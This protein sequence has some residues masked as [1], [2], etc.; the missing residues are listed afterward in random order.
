MCLVLCA[1]PL[2]GSNFKTMPSSPTQILQFQ[3]N[4]NNLGANQKC[5]HKEIQ[6]SSNFWGMQSKVQKPRGEEEV[7]CYR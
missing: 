4:I 2:Q 7:K 1:A 6:E 3:L 5:T